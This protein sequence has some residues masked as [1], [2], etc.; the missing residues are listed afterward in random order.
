VHRA[1]ACVARERSGLGGQG[2]LQYAVGITSAVAGVR[3]AGCADQ[4]LVRLRR[5][6]YRADLDGTFDALPTDIELWVL[7]IDQ[8]GFRK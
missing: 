6:R 7:V 3:T 4:V 2:R 8:G 1:V 5:G